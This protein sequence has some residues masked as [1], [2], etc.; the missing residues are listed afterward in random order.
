[1]CDNFLYVFKGAPRRAGPSGPSRESWPGARV[2]RGKRW[3]GEDVPPL[4]AGPRGLSPRGGGGLARCLSA[5]GAHGAG[6]RRRAIAPHPAAAGP[7]VTHPGDRACQGGRAVLLVPGILPPEQ[8]HSQGRSGLR[9]S[10][11]LLRK[12]R[13]LTVILSGKD[14][15][16]SGGRERNEHYRCRMTASV[17]AA[18]IA[19]PKGTAV[20]GRFQ[21]QNVMRAI[22]KVK[23]PM[24]ALR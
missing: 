6:R 23:G 2:I 15:Q 17:V 22:P 13:P 1:M 7:A 14:R 11:R 3:T 12:R 24:S 4:R 20:L 16:Q 10:R 8:D 21:A 19:T 9:P 18:A 5:G